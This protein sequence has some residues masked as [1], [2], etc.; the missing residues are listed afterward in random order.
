MSMNNILN[1]PFQGDNVVGI[2][3]RKFAPM[4]YTAHISI[5]ALGVSFG[6][7]SGQFEASSVLH[8]HLLGNWDISTFY[9]WPLLLIL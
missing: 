6:S 8:G 1:I 4:T 9:F 3:A 2:A 5:N 7:T